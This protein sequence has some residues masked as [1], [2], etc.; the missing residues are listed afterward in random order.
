MDFTDVRL[1]KLDSSRFAEIT[2]GISSN[3]YD[4]KQSFLSGKEADFADILV[5]EIWRGS[6][7]KKLFEGVD[8]EFNDAFSD[9][10]VSFV[11]LNQL[12]NRFASKKEYEFLFSSL[13][14][15]LSKIHFVKDTRFFAEFVLQNS[16][17]LKQF[18]FFF[19]DDSLE[20]LMVNSCDN[21]FVFHKQFGMCR[22]NTVFSENNVLDA[23]QKVAVTLGK[24]FSAD[25][26]L[27]DARLPDGCRANA[28]L[29]ELS[30]LGATLTIRKF[31]HVPL[32]IIDLIENGTITSEAAAF[33]WLMVDGFGTFPQN[34]LITGGSACGKTTILNV[35]SNFARL[36]ERIVSIEDTVE[37]SLPGRS[38]WVPFEARSSVAHEVSMDSLLRNAMRMRPDRIIVGEVRGSEALTFFTAMDTGHKGC[39]STIHANNAREAIVKLQE[40][41][42]S[43]PQSMLPLLDL[44]VVMQRRRLKSGGVE[45]RVTQ[46]VELSRM[47]DKVLF[48]T[49]FDYDN[50][51]NI[52]K[53]TELVGGV[54][55]KIGEVN[56]L[57]RLEV[58]SELRVRQKL[59]EWMFKQGIRKSMEVLEVIESYYYDRDKVLAAM[60][61]TD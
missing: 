6:L 59:L 45:R 41:P 49:I 44:I 26:P 28:T 29:G 17:G 9:E 37:L 42:L 1:K 32:S 18:A 11:Q 61:Q 56:S 30:P 46:I 38:N 5:K 27:L 48:G 55:E 12:N 43:V 13:V 2:G 14:K 40:R 57:T 20:E 39:L 15:L 4:I 60:K 50:S 33:L 21:V 7:Y 53:K 24:E 51:I 16:I 47:E 35:L 19:L 31:P 23:I 54:L 3:F 58:S 10:I 25:N 22:V 52:L 34:V 36:S 8:E